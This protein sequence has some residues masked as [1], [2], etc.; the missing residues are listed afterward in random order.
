MIT[1][2]SMSRSTIEPLEGRRMFSG[3]AVDPVHLDLLGLHVDTSPIT[4]DVKASARTGDGQ[5]LGNLVY[6]LARARQQPAGADYT[7]DA[8]GNVA[9]AEAS[10]V[11]AQ[12]I[13][14][15]KFQPQPGG[16]ALGDFENDRQDIAL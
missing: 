11:T 9:R 5:V 3:G 16:T 4:L 15:T 2:T 6:A 14:V 1:S 13:H 12:D 7:Y 10:Q 8:Q